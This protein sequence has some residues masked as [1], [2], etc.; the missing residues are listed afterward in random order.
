MFGSNRRI[1]ELANR[2]THFENS[3]MNN[4]PRVASLE[5]QMTNRVGTLETQMLSVERRLVSMRTKWQT[6]VDA[7]ESAVSDEQDASMVIAAL[8]EDVAEQN[9]VGSMTAELAEDAALYTEWG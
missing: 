5:S 4:L 7:N 3:L 2:L 1:D 6:L 8:R 9:V